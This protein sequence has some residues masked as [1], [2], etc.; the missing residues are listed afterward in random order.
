MFIIGCLTLTRRLRRRTFEHVS[1]TSDRP[2]VCLEEGSSDGACAEENSSSLPFKMDCYSC[3]RLLG[4]VR[5]ICERNLNR[6]RCLTIDSSRQLRLFLSVGQGAAV[7]V[8]V[9]TCELVPPSMSSAS[10]SRSA[11]FGN[12]SGA[13]TMA[14][15]SSPKAS[16]ARPKRFSRAF[17]GV[18]DS[19]RDSSPGSVLQQA[20]SHEA[21]R[22]KRD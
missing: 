21:C 22:H 12:V 5:N 16:S 13:M 7:R 20:R 4:G 10:A 1:E 6:L 19:S 17:G 2:A 3:Y 15:P 14:P 9:L 8:Q 11:E 18:W